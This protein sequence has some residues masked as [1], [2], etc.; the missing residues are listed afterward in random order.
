[1]QSLLAPAEKRVGGAVD[2]GSGPAVVSAL[3]RLVTSAARHV[4]RSGRE[5]AASAGPPKALELD[6]RAMGTP[7]PGWAPVIPERRQVKAS[8]VSLVRLQT[9][10]QQ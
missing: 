10:S 5:V 3:A 2:V 8:T 6:A 9:S 4:Q 1:M 7:S